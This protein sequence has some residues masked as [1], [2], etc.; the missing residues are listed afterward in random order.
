MKTSDCNGSEF[1]CYT[2][3]YRN[4]QGEYGMGKALLKIG[5]FYSAVVMKNIGIFI[6]LGLMRAL[7]MPDGWIENPNLYRLADIVYQTVLPLLIA[8]TSGKKVGDEP[9]GIVAAVSMVG[10]ITTDNISG[11]MGAMILGPTAGYLTHKIN[12]LIKDR[13][14]TGTE[15]LIKNLII[16]FSG[17]LLMLLAYFGLVPVL[18]V[19][20]VFL[21]GGIDMMVH[22]HIVPI[23]AVIVEPAKLLFLNNSINHGILVPLAMEQVHNTGKS[24]L[25][26]IETNPG[27]GFGILLAFYMWEKEKRKINSSY[28]LIQL[29]GG[30]HEVYFPFVLLYP[31]LIIV[32]II[33][34]GIGILV[35]EVLNAGLVGVASPGSI[36]SLLLVAP[37][38]EWYKVLIGVLASAAVSFVG[39]MAV[40]KLEN[41]GKRNTSDDINKDC[42]TLKLVKKDEGTDLKT[43]ETWEKVK[44]N[45][46]RE[47]QEEAQKETQIELQ[48]ELKIPKS[49][50]FICD[51]GFG[52]SA[53]GAAL[54]RKKL[55]KEEIEGI[56][57]SHA[58]IEEF[59]ENADLIFVQKNL[60]EMV[61]VENPRTEYYFLDNF[62]EA[63]E[64][65]TLIEGWKEIQRR[66]NK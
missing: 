41:N 36:L 44:I 25:F 52:S 10:V 1:S 45:N 50:Y 24:I 28:L 49:V 43:V 22:Q 23:L 34:G 56:Q 60:K 63:P 14:P 7:F 8:Y 31:W 5:K 20:E 19:M 33:S 55:K 62:L 26:L 4:I 46:Q 9:G 58:P 30:I 17:L 38:G 65:N 42:K 35:F 18:Q 37:K 11:V 61:G 48:I 12:N 21:S 6:T 40:L 13:I 66:E 54:F 29:I 27:P 64:F 57:V 53:M 32:V 15:M 3:V 16:G 39:A 59:P 47:I 2:I 51:G